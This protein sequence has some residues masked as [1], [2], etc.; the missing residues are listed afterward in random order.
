MS[1]PSVRHLVRGLLG[2]SFFAMAPGAVVA[3]DDA[4]GNNDD[5]PARI[6]ST[7]AE[8]REAGVKHRLAPNL[9]LSF[10]AE[11]EYVGDRYRLQNSSSR[12]REHEFGTTLQFA[13]VA[14]PTPWLG[15]ELVYQYEADRQSERHSLD[16]AIASVKVA[17]F[18]GEFGKLYLPFGVYFSRF[19]S[20]PLLEFGETRAQ[21][22]VVSYAPGSGLNTTAFLYRA[23]SDRDQGSA[24]WGYGF[25]VEAAPY[26][27][28]R[29]GGSYLSNLADA[30]QGPQLC[31]NPSDCD[32][33]AGVSAYAIATSEEV[34]VTVEFVALRSFQATDAGTSRPRAWNVEVALFPQAELSVALRLEGSADLKGA[35]ARRAGVALAWR[36]ARNVSITLEYL[37]S[38][39]PFED[40]AGDAV[41]RG[42]RIG[43]QLSLSF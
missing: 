12:A 2:W 43:A 3:A 6:Y 8:R 7:P 17:D 15:L 13:L 4:D 32:R 16:E 30:K 19:V 42:D 14:T 25:A 37:H 41:D 38:H 9:A 28:L 23:Q 24:Q 40:P 11:F 27:F 22:A 33:V 39:G 26:K 29:I 34:E 36:V 5:E 10:L 31:G 18:E 1:N 21:G 20:A 35:P